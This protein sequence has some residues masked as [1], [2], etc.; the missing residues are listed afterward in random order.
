MHGPGHAGKAERGPI[1]IA[2]V[3]ARREQA[4][5]RLD[6]DHDGFLTR[7]E[8]RAGMR[9]AHERRAQRRAAHQASPQ[10]PASE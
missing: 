5:T 7:D 8:R 4:F 9:Q 3:Q 10:T 2:D 6:A 1:A